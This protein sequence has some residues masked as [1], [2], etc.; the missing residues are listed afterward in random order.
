MTDLTNDSEKPNRLAMIEQALKDKAPGMY[1]ELQ[2]SGQLQAFL[3]GHDEEMMAS[4]EEAKKQAWEDT[5][6]NYLSFTDA[7]DSEASSPMG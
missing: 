5:M 3:E 7:S 1:E 4:Y 2:S 6:T